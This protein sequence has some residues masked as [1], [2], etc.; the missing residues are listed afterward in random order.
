M[1]VQRKLLDDTQ[2][3]V[4]WEGEWLERNVVRRDLFAVCPFVTLILYI[5]NL[6]CIQ[7]IKLKISM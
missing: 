3:P 6:I 5:E 1:G 7:K 4:S 2:K